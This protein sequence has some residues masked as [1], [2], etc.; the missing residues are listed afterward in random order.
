MKLPPYLLFDAVTATEKAA[1]AA[2][3]WV[4]L[5]DNVAADK[6]AVDAMRAALM[7]LDIAGT[8]VIG[9]GERDEAPM[10]FIG[11]EVG[12][13]T[14][15]IDIA[16]DPLEGTGICANQGD[17]SFAVLAMAPK[18]AFLYAP[19]TYM[20]KIVVGPAVPKGAVSL[21]NSVKENVA[22]LAKAH[23]KQ[24]SELTVCVLERERHNQLIADLRDCGVRVKLIGDGDIFASIETARANGTIDM[25]M[26][27]GG[28]PEGVLAASALRALDGDIQ[29]K[30]IFR[31]D[32]EYARAEKTGIRDFDKIYSMNDLA[33]GDEMIF[34]ASAVTNGTMPG[35]AYDAN[36]KVTVHTMVIDLASKSQR[37][38]CNS[39]V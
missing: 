19:D 37:I 38:I 9:E 27:S 2:Y 13:G 25:Y 30:L 11:E 34:C 15:E 31:N 26:G 39:I 28:A 16:L 6:A 3:S 33:K 7:Q 24:A 23:G 22:I 1:I 4:G 35:I 20:E 14:L 21:E 18:G 32:D 8:V 36:G 12:T 5:G 17:N 29:G 10:L